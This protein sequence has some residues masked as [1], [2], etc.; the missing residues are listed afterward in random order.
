MTGVQLFHLFF[1]LLLFCF[2]GIFFLDTKLRR[3]I[4]IRH[5][6]YNFCHVFEICLGIFLQVHHGIIYYNLHH[7]ATII[8]DYIKAV[9]AMCLVVYQQNRILE[10]YIDIKSLIM[11]LACHASWG[12]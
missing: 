5:V 11:T 4:S 3:A 1:L 12:D 8:N 6:A 9:Q 10:W 7:H 2:S